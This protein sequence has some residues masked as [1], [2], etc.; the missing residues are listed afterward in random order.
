M[1]LHHWRISESIGANDPALAEQLGDAGSAFGQGPDALAA[2]L[3]VVD[4]IVMKQAMTMAFG[5]IFL[6]LS[7][8]SVLCA[9]LVLLRPIDP[10]RACKGMMH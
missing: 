10:E 5:D 3:R 7:I 6:M 1:E 8:A 2:G 4:G 9:P